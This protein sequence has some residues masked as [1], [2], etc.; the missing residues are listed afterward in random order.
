[1]RINPEPSTI[2]PT[3]EIV[4]RN[5][6]TFVSTEEK[7]AARKFS[8]PGKL[9][10]LRVTEVGLLP[11]CCPCG[12][13][14]T[15]DFVMTTSST[16]TIATAMAS[17]TSWLVALKSGF[18]SGSKSADLLPKSVA[19]KLLLCGAALASVNA[20]WYTYVYFRRAVQRPRLSY[21]HNARYV[22]TSFRTHI[23][24]LLFI[25]SENVVINIHTPSGTKP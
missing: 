25:I 24:I 6:R 5:L 11:R 13:L 19:G 17:A 16:A 18:I 15:R 7:T 1:L 22:F 2:T 10:F 8:W 3:V 21:Q 12:L 20:V 14:L 4:I 9:Y 23:I